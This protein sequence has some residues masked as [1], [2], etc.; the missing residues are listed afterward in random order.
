MTDKEE[1]KLKDHLLVELPILI[2][3][4]RVITKNNKEYVKFHVYY[5]PL[6]MDKLLNLSL[7]YGDKYNKKSM[8]IKQNHFKIIKI[9]GKFL[10]TEPYYPLD[11]KMLFVLLDTK[12]ILITMALDNADYYEFTLSN[13]PDFYTKEKQTLNPQFNGK[14][15]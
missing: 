10:I 11:E 12:G 8:R 6:E 15:K 9:E 13:H 5:S 2:D 7:T 14:K 1:T 3:N 4:W